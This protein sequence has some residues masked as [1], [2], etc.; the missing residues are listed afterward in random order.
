MLD[1][2]IFDYNNCNKLL[3]TNLD[4]EEIKNIFNLLSIDY[5]ETKEILS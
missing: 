5:K 1:I 2:L 4:I 3:G